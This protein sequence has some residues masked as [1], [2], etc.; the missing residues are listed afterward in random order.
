MMGWTSSRDPLTQLRMDFPSEEE[1]VTYAKNLGLQYTIKSDNLPFH[2]QT[3]DDQL[4]D[5]NFLFK[6]TGEDPT[7]TIFDDTK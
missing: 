7:D 3:F 6:G 2:D 1:A 5:T 4:Y